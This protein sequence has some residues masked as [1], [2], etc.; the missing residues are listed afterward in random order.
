MVAHTVERLQNGSQ[1][2]H[3]L[4]LH[5]T[6]AAYEIANWKVI[7]QLFFFPGAICLFAN[8]L[9]A[10]DNSLPQMILNSNFF[11]FHASLPL[12]KYSWEYSGLMSPLQANLFLSYT[13]ALAYL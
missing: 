10:Y 13:S 12:M 8:P 1:C 2:R 7:L 4:W 3:I 9:A 5:L 11:A 6:A